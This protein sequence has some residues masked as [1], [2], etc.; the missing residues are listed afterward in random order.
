M[1][2]GTEIILV[3]K[4]TELKARLA[5]SR[6]KTQDAE[7]DMGSRKREQNQLNT[8][9]T[10]WE[11]IVEVQPC[12]HRTSAHLLACPHDDIARGPECVSAFVSA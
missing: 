12:A 6:E 5:T 11:S 1:W 9:T 4:L 10:A 8:D 7:R 2:Q 3:Q